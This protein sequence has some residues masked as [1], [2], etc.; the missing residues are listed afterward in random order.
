V[1]VYPILD[2]AL[3]EAHRIPLRAAVEAALSF[4]VRYV[5]IRHKSAFD[6]DALSRLEECAAL[7]HGGR[8]ILND[9]ADYAR[10]F[11]LGLHVGQEDLPPREAREI[12]GP[13]SELG[14]STHNEAQLASA[15]FASLS[16]VALGPIF[17]TKSKARPDPEVGLEKL[18]AWRRLSPLPLVAIGGITLE[19]AP[20]VLE[21]G[22]DFVSIISALW[23]APYT[24]ETF[25]HEI[26]TWLKT[27]QPRAHIKQAHSKRDLAS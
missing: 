13:E 25:G 9:R 17:G 26:E 12:L 16:Y 24:L 8:L 4:P 10:M 7:A 18:R 20:A 21:A 15:P 3:L 27:L 6:R 1:P 2:T 14:F 23:P 19:T 11:G 5:Q 22:A